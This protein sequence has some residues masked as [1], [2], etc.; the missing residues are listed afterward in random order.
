MTS[1]PVTALSILSSSPSFDLS[2]FLFYPYGAPTPQLWPRF[3]PSSS[4]AEVAATLS[5]F[6]RSS[7]LTT[8]LVSSPHHAVTILLD[9]LD[10]KNEM[11]RGYDAGQSKIVHENTEGMAPGTGN[12]QEGGMERRMEGGRDS[13]VM[14]MLGIHPDQETAESS[15]RKQ[16]SE[17]KSA[18]AFLHACL[19]SLRPSSLAR[20]EGFVRSL[21]RQVLESGE[22]NWT[23]VVQE[24]VE[25]VV[26]VCPE[27]RRETLKREAARQTAR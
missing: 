18:L 11:G 2:A 4:P 15:Y 16:S 10:E 13:Y 3:S 27:N 9:R 22:K 19:S 23:A 26:R 21:E 6:L 7:G 8:A 20:V 25:Y 12:G 14:L 5:S 24:V 1:Q 17:R